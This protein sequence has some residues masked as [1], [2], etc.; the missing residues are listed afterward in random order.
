M[1]P[2]TKIQHFVGFLFPR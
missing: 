1:L 2:W